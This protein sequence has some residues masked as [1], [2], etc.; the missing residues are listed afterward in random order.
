M[1]TIIIILF[2]FFLPKISVSEEFTRFVDN[3]DGTIHDIQTNLV[4]KKCSEGMLHNQ[5]YNSCNGYS[6][7]FDWQSALLHVKNVNNSVSSTENL[8][9]NDWRIPNIKELSSIADRNSN[10]MAVDPYLFFIM[11]N[12]HTTYAIWSST[13]YNLASNQ[14]YAMSVSEADVFTLDI[15]VEINVLLVRDNDAPN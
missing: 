10:F 1:K 9:K 14:S 8:G 13:T 11:N 6:E 4:W 3:F 7:D 2:I 15:N 12:N 5:L